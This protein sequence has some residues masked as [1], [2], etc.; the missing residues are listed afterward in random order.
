[1]GS[2]SRTFG[3]G[4]AVTAVCFLLASV[5]WQYVL[6]FFLLAGIGWSAW[7]WLS[8]LDRDRKRQVWERRKGSPLPSAERKIKSRRTGNVYQLPLRD[9]PAG[10]VAGFTEAVD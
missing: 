8:E 9:W 7:S 10:G 1:M 5:T 4:V 6:I 2:Q 3:A